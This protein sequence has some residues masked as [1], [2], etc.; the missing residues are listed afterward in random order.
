MQTSRDLIIIMQVGYEFTSTYAVVYNINFIRKKLHI[1]E[2][3]R[4][5]QNELG[6]HVCKEN[7]VTHFSIDVSYF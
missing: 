7:C 6:L 4:M 5:L 1:T 3:Y 2:C